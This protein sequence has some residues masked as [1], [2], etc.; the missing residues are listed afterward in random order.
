M[1]TIVRGLQQALT[2][3]GV[4]A[5]A[6]A[7]GGIWAF[8]A[9]FAVAAALAAAAA[10]LLAHNRVETLRWR[11]DVRSSARMIRDGWPFCAAAVIHLAYF[12]ADVMVMAFTS[13]DAQIGVYTLAY[14]AFQLLN[15]IPTV[16]AMALF[17]SLSHLYAHQ[18]DAF[19]A[20][21]RR[22][23]LTLTGMGAAIAIA[24]LGAAQVAFPIVMGGAYGESLMLFRVLLLALVLVFPSYVLMDSL[25]AAGRQHAVTYA[26]ALGAA[27]NVA[28]NV[29]LTPAYGALGAAIA[30]VITEAIIVGLLAALTAGWISARRDS[31]RSRQPLP[32]VAL[33]PAR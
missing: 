27:A 21:R 25:S 23:L 12:R 33:D 9:V 28:L 13:T 29:M 11:F 4:G 22:S 2:V 3:A 20:A 24:G 16:C 26:L 14:N 7:G 6:L 32:E 19:V 5:V 8:A 18:P 30:T 1:E 15:A 17:P 10:L 31:V